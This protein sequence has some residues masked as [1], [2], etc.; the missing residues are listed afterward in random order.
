DQ[1]LRGDEANLLQPIDGYVVVN[2]RG[3]WVFY[4]D[5]SV[6]FKVNNLF[7]TDYETFGLLGDPQEVIPSFSNPRFLTPGAPIG[8][9]I[10][11]RIKI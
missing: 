1:F 4:Q 8:G 3:E 9:W 10:G 6:F 7:D 2:L 11:L 5:A